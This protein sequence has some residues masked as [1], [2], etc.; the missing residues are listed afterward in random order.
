M[1]FIELGTHTQKKANPLVIANSEVT[2]LPDDFFLL[3][4]FELVSTS[5]FSDNN[6]HQPIISMIE[7]TES[8]LYI[9]STV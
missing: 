4:P 7:V 9:P 3:Y 2:C 1:E 8:S 6:H 5:I